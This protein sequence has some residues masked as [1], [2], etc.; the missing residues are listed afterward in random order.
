MSIMINK[1]FYNFTTF[2]IYLQMAQSFKNKQ[3]HKFSETVG[4][5]ELPRQR[6]SS[7]NVVKNSSPK[8]TIAHL[9]SGISGISINRSNESLHSSTSESSIPKVSS[10][11]E[12]KEPALQSKEDNSDILVIHYGPKGNSSK[13]PLQK[14]KS[15]RKNSKSG[16]VL[17]RKEKCEKETNSSESSSDKDKKL[18][19]NLH[20]LVD[21]KGLLQKTSGDN[22]ENDKI[23]SDE[24]NAINK[25]KSESSSRKTSSNKEMT[26]DE[27]SSSSATKKSSKFRRKSTGSLLS[28]SLPPHSSRYHDNES[29]EHD[30]PITEEEELNL[31]AT[32]GS[33]TKPEDLYAVDTTDSSI[34][35]YKSSSNVRTVKSSKK[36]FN[37]KGSSFDEDK[38]IN[39]NQSLATQKLDTLPPPAQ[40]IF[41]RSHSRSHSDGS[42]QINHQSITTSSTLPSIGNDE[43][44]LK[45]LSSTGGA[46]KKRFMEDGGQSITAAADGYF[47]SPLPGQ[48]LIEFLSSREFNKANAELDRENAHFHIAEACISTFERVSITKYNTYLIYLFCWLR[49]N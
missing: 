31:P 45:K 27:S 16:S 26:S 32:I 9:V 7:L 29:E 15:F 14:R 6:S 13:P 28:S 34:A 44:D 25:Q 1:L 41:K 18:S 17:N 48:N 33:V 4:G 38:V 23:N 8:S 40:K 42:R 21:T 2:G 39:D 11:V 20:K 49:K 22:S 35:D 47:P 12:G 10:S 43:A 24:S 19:C 5:V 36:F 37:K 46:I 3:S 30:T